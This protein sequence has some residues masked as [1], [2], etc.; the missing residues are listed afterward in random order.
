MI[1]SNARFEVDDEP[2]LVEHAGGFAR[3]VTHDCPRTCPGAVAQTVHTFHDVDGN[4]TNDHAAQN[5]IAFVDLDQNG[6]IEPG[7]DLILV[8]AERV[9]VIEEGVC[10]DF[11][12]R[13]ARAAA[14]RV[15]RMLGGAV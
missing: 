1:A 5:R 7:R 14:E 8:R 4:G 12:R 11:S 10:F 13:W 15:V 9:T 3:V 2:T 6:V